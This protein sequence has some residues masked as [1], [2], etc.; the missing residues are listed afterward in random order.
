MAARYIYAGA[1][2]AAE[3]TLIPFGFGIDLIFWSRR[4]HLLAPPVVGKEDHFWGGQRSI[5]GEVK[6][7]ADSTASIIAGL[8]R[9]LAQS[10][11]KGPKYH[12][13]ATS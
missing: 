11:L 2:Q 9:Y 8:M 5:I 10:G 4:F 12:H 7:R 1:W 3:E 13:A 6:E